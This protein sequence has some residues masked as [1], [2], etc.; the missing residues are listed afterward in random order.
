[1]KDG[2]AHI[3]TREEEINIRKALNNNFIFKDITPEVL[4]LILNE[5]IFFP[6]P[7]NRII[8]EEGDVGNIFYILDYGKVKATKKGKIKKN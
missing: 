1:M 2:L 4:D 7:K 5:L 8:Y 6:F 3:M